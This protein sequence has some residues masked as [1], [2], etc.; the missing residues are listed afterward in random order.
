[1]ALVSIPVG[2]AVERRQASSPW[3]DV[4]WRPVAVFHGVASAVPWT[5][6]DTR[7][8]STTFYVGESTIEL[9]R[10]EAA[11]YRDNLLT[12]SPLLWV[13]LRPTGSTPPLEL[14]TVTADP[15]EGEAMTAIGNDL[16]EPV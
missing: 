9:H 2:V 8:D 3:I 4:L 16:V 14:L 11:N 15:A 10:T 7:V 12:G 13:I 1:M 5:V 6:I